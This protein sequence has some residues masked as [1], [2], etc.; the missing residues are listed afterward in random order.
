MRHVE[1]HACDRANGRTGP[2]FRTRAL[3]LVLLPGL[4]SS[5]AVADVIF[6]GPPSC[7]ERP[8]Q[9]WCKPPDPAAEKKQ[10]TVQFESASSHG[11]EYGYE[12]ASV[13]LAYTMIAC[14][15]EVQ[16]AYSLDND[17]IQVSEAY[18][19]THERFWLPDMAAPE[20]SSIGFEATVYKV[21]YGAREKVADVSDQFAGE[22]LGF[23]CASGQTKRVGSVSELI[24]PNASRD[25]IRAYLDDLVLWGATAV[26]YEPLRSGTAEARIAAE[27][28]KQRDWG[29]AETPRKAPSDKESD[30]W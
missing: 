18:Y 28:K 2:M 8:D 10:V 14:A 26:P 6:V 23:G 1:A 15:G 12:R 9:S 29:P 27:R 24:G 19:D 3:L 11:L 22:A 25:A 30:W 5:G 17:S 20:L 16:V 21:T 4:I 13:D 7:T